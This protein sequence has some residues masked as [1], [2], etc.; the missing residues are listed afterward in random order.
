MDKH[1]IFDISRSERRTPRRLVARTYKSWA[2]LSV[3]GARGFEHPHIVTKWHRTMNLT[4]KGAEK[5]P[6]QQKK[7]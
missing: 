4:T 5:V 6:L 3:I 7:L 2:W 1:K